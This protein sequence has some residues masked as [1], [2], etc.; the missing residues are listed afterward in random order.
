MILVHPVRSAERA[1]AALER[2]NQKEAI[3]ELLHGLASLGKQHNELVE[4]V[5]ELEKGQQ[6]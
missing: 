5:A 6:S 2:G 3:T 1:A 4:R